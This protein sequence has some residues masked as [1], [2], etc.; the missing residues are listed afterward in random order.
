MVV[1]FTPE[2]TA[3]LPIK[4]AKDMCIL[5]CELLDETLR[6]RHMRMVRLGTKPRILTILNGLEQ[7]ASGM[8]YI[9][10]RRCIAI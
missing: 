6:Q 4:H 1:A 9:H 10:S 3:P 2:C 8:L 7:V 5:V